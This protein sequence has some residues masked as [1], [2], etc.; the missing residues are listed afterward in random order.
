MGETLCGRKNAFAIDDVIGVAQQKTDGSANNKT[1]DDVKHSNK[2]CQDL[3]NTITNMEYG[4]VVWAYIKPL[5]SGKVVFTP[6]TPQTRLIMAGANSTFA[7]AS[8]I[9]QFAKLWINSSDDMEKAMNNS[10]ISDNVLVSFI[11]FDPFAAGG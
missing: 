4:Q 5:M 10:A 2:L 7:E 1:K 9:Q 8:R 3:Y 11:L 6:N